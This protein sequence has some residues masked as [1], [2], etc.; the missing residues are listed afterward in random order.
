[1]TD[2]EVRL[3]I[4]RLLRGLAIEAVHRGWMPDEVHQKCLNAVLTYAYLTQ[5]PS[6]KRKEAEHGI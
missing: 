4:S 3:K 6:I 2:S 5:P 1:M